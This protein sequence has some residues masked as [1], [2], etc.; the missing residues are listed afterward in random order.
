MQGSNQTGQLGDGALEQRTT[1]T[2]VAGL[3]GGSAIEGVSDAGNGVG[4]CTGALEEYPVAVP[5]LGRHGFE[6]GAAAAT[7]DAI[8]RHRGQ[9]LET[10]EWTRDIELVVEP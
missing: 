2:P 10:Q 6:P 4:K 3:A 9:T 7:A 1:P 5:A 8:V